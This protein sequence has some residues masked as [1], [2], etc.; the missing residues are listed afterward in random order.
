MAKNQKLGS[1]ARFKAIENSLSKKGVNNPAAVAASIG[2]KKY[3]KVK[4]S[5]LA[6]AGKPN[7]KG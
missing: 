5:K 3:G 1:G 7:K 6:Q 2:I 4:M